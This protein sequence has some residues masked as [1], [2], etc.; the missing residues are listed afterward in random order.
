MSEWVFDTP[1]ARRITEPGQE[2]LGRLLDALHREIPL[3]TALDVGCGIGNFIGFLRSRR[4]DVVGIDARAYNIEEARTR[5]PDVEFH[6]ANVEEGT[7]EIGEFDVVLCFDLLYHLENPFRAVRNLEAVT[8]SV[9]I[10]ETMQIHGGRPAFLVREEHSDE[11]QSLDRVALYPSEGAVAAMLYRAGFRHVYRVRTLPNHPDFRS[12]F[13][14]RRARTMM[15]ASRRRLATRLLEPLSDPSAEFDPWITP[16]G[17]LRTQIQRSGRIA[18]AMLT[19]ESATR[20]H[21]IKR[22]WERVFRS[23]P[24]P[25]RVGR[26][27]WWLSRNDAM[28]DAVFLRSFEPSERAAVASLLRPGLTMFDVGAHHGFYTLLASRVVGPTG[29]VVA[30]EPS[31]RERQRLRTHIA[32]N[33]CANVRVESVALSSGEGERDLFVVLGRD[34]GCNSLRPPAV[35]ESVLPERIHATSLDRFLET[36][37]IGPPDFMKVDVEGGELDLLKGAMH[38]LQSPSRPIILCEVEDQRTQPWGYAAGE[39]LSFLSDLGFRW[40][41]PSEGGHL[42]PVTGLEERCQGN[43]VAVPPEREVDVTGLIHSGVA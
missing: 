23:F 25:T 20:R 15:V 24:L 42:V 27:L 11:D 9:L 39:I 26:G 34:T 40:Y 12:S 6:V 17:R 29:S 19:G 32:L 2:A 28:G 4:H 13:T 38:L 21:Y 5:W 16:V 3:E 43:F 37:G 14:R 10:V 41:R 35:E 22:L 31:R 33:R 18:G 7:G 8:R 1:E 36:T 30:F